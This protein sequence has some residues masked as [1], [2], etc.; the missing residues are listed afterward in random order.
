MFPPST[1]IG[2]I[3]F[4]PSI[5]FAGPSRSNYG[6]V[7]YAEDEDDIENQTNQVMINLSPLF[8]IDGA[9]KNRAHVEDPRS[10]N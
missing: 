6:S 5:N 2:K 8:S 1:T 9:L 10:Q 4:G 7:D 3:D